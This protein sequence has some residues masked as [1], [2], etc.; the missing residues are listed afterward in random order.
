MKRTFS[1][2][3]F[4]ML[5]V[6]SAVGCAPKESNY[7]R[8]TDISQSAEIY[9]STSYTTQERVA[10]L[11]SKM[12]IEDKAGQMVQGEQ[13]AVSDDDMY[14]MGLGS[15][16]SGGGSAPDG[17]SS[18]TSWKGKIDGLQQAALSRGLKIPFVYGLDA[19]HGHNNAYGAVIFPH[20][21]GL[22]AANDPLLTERM[23]AF[24][25]EEMKLTGIL[26]NFSPCV[27][28][29]EDPRWGRTYESFS[30]D[31]QIV[32]EL[33]AAYLRG[34]QESGV[35]A[36][37]KHYLAD[38]GTAY[39]TGRDGYLLDRGD[40]IMTE[41]RLRTI[42]LAPYKRLVE[43]GVQCVMVSYSSFNGVKAHENR[44][45]LTDVLKDEL[46]FGGFVISDWEG[47]TEINAPTFEEQVV[48]SVNA[49]VDM[50]MQPY[51]YAEAYL[52]IVKGAQS[53]A[54]PMARI[55]D[56]VSRILTVKF[57]LGLFD[58][59]YMENTSID[60][61]ELGSAQGRGIARQLVEK[62]L[63]L[64]KNDNE[65]LPF[66]PGQKIF[67]IGEA[68]DNI[69]IQCGGWTMQWQGTMN[70]NATPG[71]TIL[72]ALIT[73]TEDYDLQI[74]TDRSKAD[75]ADVVLLGV[76]EMPYAEW[77]G[78]TEDLSPTGKCGL[79]SNRNDI[80]FAKG[81]GK[82]TVTLIV[83]GRHVLISDYINDWDSVVMCYLPGTEGSGVTAP[84]VGAV[85]FT[86]RLAMP[87]Y[88]SVDDIGRE[89][90]QLLYDLGYGLTES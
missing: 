59:P 9:L 36:T 61:A 41:E 31:P 53:G 8:T 64:L 12:H 46:G 73:C 39:G 63:V 1:L 37:A 57:D 38:G 19:V 70:K 10:D 82:P 28:I 51:N 49:G 74:I 6:I 26:F 15:V 80:D 58:D 81:L 23:G 11:L 77:E 72:E 20:N 60:V 44:Y 2:M 66:T 62:S 22:G 67:V 86:G 79:A 71:T 54:I 45:L 4:L 14:N 33:A 83:A 18:V 78:D 3:L 24:V 65:L 76:G 25:G 87:W 27:A 90:V 89:N 30:T 68:L 84:L 47:I 34:Q 56:A 85:P 52:A 50:L 32:T 75:Q 42:H 35:L 88:K 5:I 43:D 17:D 69:G 55:D 48:I 29:A 13:W 40:A 7:P 21:I 16:F